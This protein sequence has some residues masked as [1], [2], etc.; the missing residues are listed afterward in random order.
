MSIVSI[1]PEKIESILVQNFQLLAEKTNKPVSEIVLFFMLKSPTEA[2]VDFENKEIKLELP[3][4]YSAFYGEIKKFI[5]NA[6]KKFAAG[7]NISL[8]NVNVKIEITTT[9][10]LSLTLMNARQ[11]VNQITVADFLNET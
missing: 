7:E 5:T 11:Q 8:Q 10:Q 9:L 6:L 3:F 1:T 4:F 2:K